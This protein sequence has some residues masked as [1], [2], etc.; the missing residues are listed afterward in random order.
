M[1]N[2]EYPPARIKCCI[3]DFDSDIV[4]DSNNFDKNFLDALDVSFHDEQE[5]PAEY[6]EIAYVIMT[7]GS[8]GSPKGVCIYRDAFE[9]VIE[10]ATGLFGLSDRDI[11][12]QYS[13]VSFDMGICD[14][15]SFFSKGV[16]VVPVVGMDRIRPASVIGKYNITFWYSVP[17]VLDLMERRGDITYANLKSLRVMAFGGAILF[18][19]HVRELFSV[20]E[21]M[22]IINTYG[23]TEITIFSSSISLNSSN[24]E[25]YCDNG[26]VCIGNPIPE[27][28]QKLHKNENG[29]EVVI[30]GRHVMAGYLSQI[31]DSSC[32]QAERNSK[33]FFTGD[34][35]REKGGALYFVSRNDTQVKL[36]GNR[37]DITEIEALIRS[38]D[39]GNAVVIEAD[40]K[41][42]AFLSPEDIR[43]RLPEIKQYLKDNLPRYS[44]PNRYIFLGSL[45]KNV[46]GKYD[47]QRLK[48]IAKDT[49]S[50]VLGQ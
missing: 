17:T 29:S 44:L 33:S 40:S 8:T 38:R 42:V 27:V 36:N 50:G 41:L 22:V 32:N 45:P 48:E 1:V 18:E 5:E 21:D 13:N 35:V 20:R 16:T 4:L 11:G 15:F 19:K 10:T 9:D 14:V 25:N 7:S 23:P 37:I 34:I 43:N 47:R 24:Y 31:G 30:T 49:K 39:I 46:N 12:G 2:P 26:T 3:S 28:K 6:N